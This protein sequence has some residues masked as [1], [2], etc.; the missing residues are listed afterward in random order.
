MWYHYQRSDDWAKCDANWWTLLLLIN[1]VYPRDLSAGC[2]NHSWYLAN[3]FKFFLVTLPLLVCYVF[4]SRRGAVALILLV[5]AVSIALST[6]DTVSALERAYFKPWNRAPP[7][8]WGV[9]ASLLY[10]RLKERTAELSVVTLAAVGETE[11]A[12]GT[13]PPGRKWSETDPLV[14]DGHGD[15]RCLAAVH[16]AV[17]R[18]WARR[19]LYAVAAALMWTGMTLSWAKY[20]KDLQSLLRPDL[21][22]QPWPK[23]YQHLYSAY[24]VVGWGVGLGL[25]VVPWTL[26]HGSYVRQGLEHPVFTPLSRLTYAIYL[27]HPVL[28]LYLSWQSRAYHTWHTAE[29]ATFFLSQALLAV[30]VSVFLYLGVEKPVGNWVDLLAPEKKPARSPP[31]PRPPSSPQ[32]PGHSTRSS[33]SQGSH[34]ASE[35]I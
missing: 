27:V 28:M 3:D 20:S 17:H 26:G 30:L 25:L 7:Y 35:P 15:S 18:G 34:S 21:R 31:P 8:F 16:Y 5:Q 6:K 24:Y 1:D 14:E 32:T 33:S 4:Y 10:Q 23:L 29:V 22:I 13:R 11:A 2:F 19:L 12:W 9:L